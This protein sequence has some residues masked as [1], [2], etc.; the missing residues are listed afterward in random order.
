MEDV[1]E[2]WSIMSVGAH[3]MHWETA[4]IVDGPA[5]LLLAVQGSAVAIFVRTR[6]FNIVLFP[7]SK[8]WAIRSMNDCTIMH[9]KSSTV[10]V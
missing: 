9:L 4:N 3:G 10:R 8:H 5:R 6:D 1:A 7:I 2:Y